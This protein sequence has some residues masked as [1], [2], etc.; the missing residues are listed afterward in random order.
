MNNKTPKTLYRKPEAQKIVIDPL[1]LIIGILTILIIF[2]I[3]GNIGA[4]SYKILL[5]NTT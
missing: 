1:F 4:S 3:N 2:L 5:A